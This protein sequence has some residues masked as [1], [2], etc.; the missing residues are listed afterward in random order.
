ML[1][2]LQLSLLT[3]V[4][5][6]VIVETG[7][8]PIE[9]FLGRHG[10]RLRCTGAWWHISLCEPLVPQFFA[11][12]LLGLAILYK[13]F[14]LRLKLVKLEGVHLRLLERHNILREP[15]YKSIAV[16]IS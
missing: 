10:D 14:P 12:Y 2:L 7:T 3:H 16:L 5:L 9:R 8:G 1:L 13:D 6:I 11:E 15:V 4:T